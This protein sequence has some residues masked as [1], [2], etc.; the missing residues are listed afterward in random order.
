MV[1]ADEIHAARI[2]APNGPRLRHE[3]VQAENGCPSG[4]KAGKQTGESGNRVDSPT[5]HGRG[6]LRSSA[7]PTPQDH[8][9][10]ME[11]ADLVALLTKRLS[12]LLREQAEVRL[13]EVRTTNTQFDKLRESV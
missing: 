7:G 9:W 6:R 13:N 2:S 4:T 8:D 10:R 1:P 12:R 5:R 3:L 11:E